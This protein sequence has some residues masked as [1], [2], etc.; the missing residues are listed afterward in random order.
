M[1]I[2][3]DQLFKNAYGNFALGAFNVFNAEQVHGVM[4]GARAAQMPVILQMTPVARNYMNDKMLRAII[5]SAAE[6]YPEVDFAIHLDHGNYD[7]CL[8]AISSEDYHSVMIDASHEKFETNIGITSDVVKRAHS[9]DIRVEAELGVL[10][11]VEDD[12]RIDDDKARYTQPEQVVEFVT[13][14]RCDSLAIAI[15]TSHGAYKFAGNQHLRLDILKKIQD[16]LPGY[17][18]VLHGASAVHDDEIKRINQAGGKLRQ[19][20]KGTDLSDLQRSI[21]LGVCKVNIATDTRLI[22]TRV[23]REF[24]RNTPDLFD[25]VVPGKEFMNA[26][27]IM[28]KEKIRSLVAYKN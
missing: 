1:R 24:F 12:T 27:E 6:I 7:H 21:A 2:T 9:K 19:D 8:D 5:H 14:T 28:V 16:M 25:P 4:R 18:I 15:G 3:T 11:G 20:A 13:R 23:H 10:S 26:M 17:P 22:W